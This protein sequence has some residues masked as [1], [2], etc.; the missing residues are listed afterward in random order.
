VDLQQDLTA[1]EADGKFAI[2]L[3]PGE[4]YVQ[5]YEVGFNNPVYVYGAKPRTQN[6]RQDAN[7]Q[8]T[9][10]YH[11]TITS[12][13]S[14][15]DLANINAEVDTV[16][17]ETIR[18]Y[19]NFTDGYVGDATQTDS[20][21]FVEPFNIGN[22]PPVTYHILTVDDIGSIDANVYT[23]VYKGKNSAVV[24]AASAPVRGDTIGGVTIAYVEV[25]IPHLLD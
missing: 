10:G 20:Q 5:G 12:L 7:V 24:T 2:K 6:F 22:T 15:P 11:V 25:S 4:A 19:R 23:T 16:G 14:V 21:G 3:S 13:N 8:I 17:L 18:L 1:Q 9:N